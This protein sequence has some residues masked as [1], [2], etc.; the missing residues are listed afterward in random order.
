MTKK[1]SLLSDVCLQTMAESLS[2]FSGAD[3]ESLC[4]EAG[5]AAITRAGFDVEEVTGN[6]F[7]KVLENIKSSITEEMM[8]KYERFERNNR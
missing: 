3:V 8:D 1:N 4:K 6:D 5:L 7:S 2:G